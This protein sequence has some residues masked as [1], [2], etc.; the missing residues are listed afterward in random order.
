MWNRNEISSMLQPRLLLLFDLLLLLCEVSR[1]LSPKRRFWKK[2][3]VVLVP[4]SE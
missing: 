4:W 1:G 3:V 2:E